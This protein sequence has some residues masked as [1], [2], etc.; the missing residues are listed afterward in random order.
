MKTKAQLLSITRNIMTGKYQ[1]AFELS[2]YNPDVHEDLTGDLLLTAEKYREKRSKNANALF[3]KLCGAIATEK[4]AHGIPTSMNAEKNELI[5]KYGQKMFFDG[6]LAIYKTNAP[7]EYMCEL[8]R[9]HTALIKEADAYFYQLYR[10]TSEYD[11]KEMSV[12]ITGTIEDASEWGISI[13]ED[14]EYIEHLIRTWKGEA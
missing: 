4:T 7:P 11:S 12:L 14:P 10:N 3:H 1:A 5:S 2:Y 9:P 13:Q 6:D 8:A